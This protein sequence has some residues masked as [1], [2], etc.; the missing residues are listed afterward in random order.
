MLTRLLVTALTDETCL[1][2]RQISHV[3]PLDGVVGR[4]GEHLSRL[5]RA[6]CPTRRI[7]RKINDKRELPL[8]HRLLDLPPGIVTFQLLSLIVELSP[9]AD[10]QLNLHKPA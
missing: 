7:P 3:K 10:A 8:S 2:S 6:D 1:Y 4:L 5:T 9:L